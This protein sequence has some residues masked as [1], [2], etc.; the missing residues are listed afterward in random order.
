[1]TEDEV[2]RLY[3]E[4]G[5][6]LFRRCLAYLG[7]ASRAQDA[8]QEVF[9]RALRGAGAF[10]GDANPRTWLCRIADHL[11]IDLLRRE[12]RNPVKVSA[13]ARL[14]A[15]VEDPGDAFD[16]ALRRDDGEALLVVRRL[17]DALDAPMRR[18]AVLHFMDQLTQEELAREIGVSRRTIGKRLKALHAR[19]RVLCGPGD[20]S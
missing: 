8:L 9:V 2:A 6:V 16:S 10:R 17:M 7:D 18:L 14:A 20:A 3:T 1:M 19:A 12:R 5:Y 11:C 15:D 4:Y 13:S